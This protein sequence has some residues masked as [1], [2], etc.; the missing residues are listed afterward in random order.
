MNL[1][2]KQFRKIEKKSCIKEE[3][4]KTALDFK[5]FFDCYNNHFV[6]ELPIS[7]SFLENIIF[8]LCDMSDEA[9]LWI[10]KILRELNT[11]YLLKQ[12]LIELTFL[13]YALKKHV[14]IK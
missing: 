1:Y 7:E 2:E 14:N 12:F 9:V 8:N 6:D 4:Q 10:R 5:L 3:F 11:S 13:K